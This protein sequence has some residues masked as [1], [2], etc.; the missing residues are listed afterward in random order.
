MSPPGFVVTAAWQV[1][2][3]LLQ[4]AS[5]KEAGRIAARGGGLTGPPARLPGGFGAPGGGTR[6]KRA[7]GTVAGGVAIGAAADK[8]GDMLGFGRPKRRYRRMQVTNM[9][10]LDRA[11]RRL[12]G[13]QKRVKKAF[14]I[15]GDMKPR[16]R[17]GCR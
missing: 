10:A 9:R 17:R 3:K 12:D 16:K 4:R 1:G 11:L 7:A 2:R 14:S 15:S 6:I 8:A 5:K 13:F